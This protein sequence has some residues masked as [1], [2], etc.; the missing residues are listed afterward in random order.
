[1]LKPFLHMTKEQLFAPILTPPSLSPRGYPAYPHP[2]PPP[3]H[4][5]CG[6]VQ[7]LHTA[8]WSMPASAASSQLYFDAPGRALDDVCGAVLCCASGSF[9]YKNMCSG[10]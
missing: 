1:M 10:S 5:H 9:I 7:T 3:T 4:P 8:N 6:P 2:P